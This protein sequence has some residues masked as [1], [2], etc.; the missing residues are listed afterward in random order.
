VKY[1]EHARGQQLG[2]QQYPTHTA[3]AT[4]SIFGTISRQLSSVAQHMAQPNANI[5]M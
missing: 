5:S 1:R 3:A 2:Q 4:P